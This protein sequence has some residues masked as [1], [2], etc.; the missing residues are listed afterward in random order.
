ML[1]VTWFPSCQFALEGVNAIASN[2]R[3]DQANIYGIT[4][5][6]IKSIP[7][8][9]RLHLNLLEPDL[10]DASRPWIVYSGT[11]ALS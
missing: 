8:T 4:G 11:V 9:Y 10:R 7:T 1:A 3:I 6:V 5:C 2:A